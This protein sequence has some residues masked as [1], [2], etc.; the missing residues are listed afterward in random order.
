MELKKSYE[1]FNS[2][3]IAALV[4]KFKEKLLSQ[5]ERN[6]EELSALIEVELRDVFLQVVR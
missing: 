2:F 1:D 3:C 5:K 6:E 4:N